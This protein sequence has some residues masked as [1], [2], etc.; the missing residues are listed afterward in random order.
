MDWN[1]VVSNMLMTRNTEVTPRYLR[2]SMKTKT[3]DLERL[4]NIIVRENKA[5]LYWS[6]KWEGDTKE[7]EESRETPESNGKIMPNTLKRLISRDDEP[8]TGCAKEKMLR[9]TNSDEVLVSGMDD[10]EWW[11]TV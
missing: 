3:S 9:E 2:V 7:N 10:N 8:R 1:H 11:T 5:T 6:D 4:G